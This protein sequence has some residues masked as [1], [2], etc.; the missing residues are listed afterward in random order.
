MRRRGHRL[1]T[2]SSACTASS[3]VTA[4]CAATLC[5]LRGHGPAPA[6]RSA[7]LRGAP[8]PLLDCRRDGHVSKG[9]RRGDRCPGRPVRPD[10]PTGPPGD[11]ALTR[12]RATDCSF[13]QPGAQRSV[14]RNSR[15]S[16][17]RPSRRPSR[18]PH[19]SRPGSRR[20]P[21]PTPTY[22]RQAIPAI[23]DRGRA[24]AGFSIRQV[25]GG[26]PLDVV[27]RRPRRGRRTA[28]RRPR[29]F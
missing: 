12:E 11:P 13:G 8:E 22:S 3:A 2:Y 17:I 21:F 23:R 18:A 29:R 19:A 25:L 26:M 9:P 10:A 1:G 4:Q 5:L 15:T 7:E 16:T 14:V 28:R 24:S 20:A 6:R 27:R